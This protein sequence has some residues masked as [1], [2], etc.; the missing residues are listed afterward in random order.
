MTTKP[1]MSLTLNDYQQQAQ[2]TAQRAD[3]LPSDKRL[4]GFALGLT[5][6]AGEVA[7]L[8]KKE[9][10][11]GHARDTTKIKAELGDVLWYLAALAHE[12]GL[13]LED[14]AAANIAKLKARYPDPEGFSE[15]R[16]KARGAEPEFTDGDLVCTSRLLPYDPSAPERALAKRLD[17]VETRL[18]NLERCDCEFD[19]LCGVY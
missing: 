11:H 5:G 2:R 9:T 17:A 12:Y 14:V 7:D 1:V 16:S 18:S 8:V 19:C 13:T 6:E 15:A 4:M 3:P 10:T